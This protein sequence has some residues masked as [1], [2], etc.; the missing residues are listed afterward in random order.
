MVS[1]RIL[2]IATFVGVVFAFRR[3]GRELFGATAAGLLGGALATLI[4]AELEFWHTGQPEAFGG[5]LTVF[6]LVLTTGPGTSA[7]TVRRR[8]VS[9]GAGGMLFGLA[10]LMKPPLGGGA[11]VCAAYLARSEYERLRRPVDFVAPAIVM[12]A[13]SV[14]PI[15][16]CALWFWA[17]GAWPEL[18]WTLFE[19]T[20]GYT[21]LGWTGSALGFYGYGL[22]ELLMGF[23][24]LLPVGV[25]AALVL[26]P[27]HGRERE[28]LLLVAGIASVH[29][30]GIALQ[31]KFFQ[32]HYSAT[33]PLVAWVS[34]L[35]LYK[36]WRRAL[37]FKA[38]GVIAYAAVVGALVA[39]RV[40]L[41]HNPGTFWERTAD[42]MAF[43]FTRSP[44]R[45]ELD[46]KL[47]NVADYDLDIDR[48]AG[49]AVARLGSP[50]EPIF[51]WG[52]EPAVYWFARRDPASRYIYD[53]PQ[54][55][56]WQRDRARVELLHDL[57]S[58]PP[59][60]VVVQHG[61]Y[62]NYVTGDDLDSHA[63]LA[64]FPELASLLDNRYRLAETVGDLD[65]YTSK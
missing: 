59:A 34:G 11:I 61:D 16:L 1:V 43:L 13:G 41:R 6:A 62:F 46:R 22:G 42:R 32:Y 63:A 35:G 30:A 24:F 21:A 29:V 50:Q 38:A 44:S 57:S 10:F 51:V 23:S 9:W 54:R 31:A 52:F 4:H 25:A 56:S 37:N 39:S 64:T 5:A 14:A 36:L 3:L 65:I 15:G 53:V 8:R 27:I 26:R 19:F 7:T 28:A 20:P 12:A 48:R 33:L 40:A 58:R 45:T 49:E 60:A 47:Y 2:E 17:R 18:S 55:A